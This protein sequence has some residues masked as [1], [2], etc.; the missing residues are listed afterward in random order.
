MS[1]IICSECGNNVSEFADKCPNCG[2][3]IEIIKQNCKIEDEI[4]GHLYTIINGEKKDVTYFVNAILSGDYMKDTDSLI[5][6]CKKTRKDLNISR[7]DLFEEAIIKCN[8]A[9][10]EFNCESMTDFHNR[11]QSI[12]SSKPKCPTCGSTNIRKI[13]TGE[14]VASVVGFGLLSKKINKTWKCNNCGH[15]W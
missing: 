10:K 4:D 7:D 8:G 12:Q 9:P 14:R 6:F 11:Q 2:C 5:A 1:L 13:G 3:P 15:T